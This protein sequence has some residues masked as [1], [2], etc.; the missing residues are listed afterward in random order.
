VRV[1]WSEPERT[2]SESTALKL[3]V[4]RAVETV[5][6]D[7][8]PTESRGHVAGGRAAVRRPKHSANFDEV[9]ESPLELRTQRCR[10][11]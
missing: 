2:I 6:N 5:M 3:V 7:F 9:D 11:R 8:H 1:Q 10:A 4:A